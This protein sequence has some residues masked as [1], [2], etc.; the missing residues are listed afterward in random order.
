[1]NGTHAQ[2][3]RARSPRGNRPLLVESLETR[4]FL[5][6]S[7]ALVAQIAA[8]NSDP[9]SAILDL[10]A[11]QRT[12]TEPSAT[13]VDPA[14]TAPPSATR[15][16]AEPPTEQ[17]PASGGT[18]GFGATPQ[19]ASQPPAPPRSPSDFRYVLRPG[20]GF[21]GATP[22]PA[23]RGTGL[24]SS[25]TPIADWDVVP[26]QVVTGTLNVGVVAWHI[27]EAGMEKVEFSANGG[28]WTPVTAMEMNPDTGVTEY[29]ATFRADMFNTGPVELRAVAYPVVGQPVVL[30]SLMLYADPNGSFANRVRH[31][32][33]TGS[34][35]TGDGSEAKPFRTIAK[36][37]SSLQSAFGNADGGT[38]YLGAG[39]YDGSTGS[40]TTNNAWLTISAAPGLAK[41][42]VTISGYSGSPARL[43]RYDGVT[44]RSAV[45]NPSATNPRHAWYSNSDLRGSNLGE[46]I[47][48]AGA[49]HN[50]S[51]WVQTA[52]ATDVTVGNTQNGI[53]NGR[54]IRNAVFDGIGSDALSDSSTMINV[55]VR[56]IDTSWYTGPS[57]GAPHPDVYQSY[58]NN[59][60]IIIY[61]LEAT[62]S[63][64]AEGIFAGGTAGRDNW[65]VVNAQLNTP[66]NTFHLGGAWDNAFFLSSAFN[67]APHWLPGWMTASNFVLEA[68]T[69]NGGAPGSYAGVIIR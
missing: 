47:D 69:W 15:V 42:N 22:T 13:K 51:T 50:G 5:D 56:N 43:V 64:N 4:R 20:S 25:S 19:G 17:P 38:I 41:N 37:A 60:D 26:Y 8:A 9:V 39:S 46:N 62:Q 27:N 29:F 53:R 6:A 40:V 2:T 30:P 65:A 31:V 14:L 67:G 54:L 63:I 10:A 7:A 33:T 1:M 52:Y 35:T 21:S 3:Y 18:E 28:G 48:W 57:S 45:P 24:G 66:V 36:A 59:D 12:A 61:N 55:T 49:V 16:V 32:T 23:K 11:G 68:V 34:D 44:M 58:A